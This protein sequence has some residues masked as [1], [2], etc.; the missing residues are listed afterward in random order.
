MVASK[1]PT[2][3]PLDDMNMGPQWN[4][5]VTGKPKNLEKNVSHCH[6]VHHKSHME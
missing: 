4:D 2:V 1:R 6:F 5:I 3:H